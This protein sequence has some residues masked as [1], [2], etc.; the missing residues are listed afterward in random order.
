MHTQTCTHI[1]IPRVRFSARLLVKKIGIIQHSWIREG[2]GVTGVVSHT[3]T[4]SFAAYD[5]SQDLVNEG[6]EGI[7]DGQNQ[8]R[9]TRGA[10]RRPSH[11]K[12][13]AT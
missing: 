8:P 1:H 11:K 12:N 9:L 5:F 6:E 3:K 4:N 13:S 7:E 10:R 2:E